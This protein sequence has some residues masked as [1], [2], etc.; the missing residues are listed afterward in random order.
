MKDIEP[1]GV[2]V[3]G[4]ADWLALKNIKYAESDDEVSRLFEMLAYHTFKASSELGKLRGSFKAFKGSQLNRG[5]V[6]GKVFLSSSYIYEKDLQEL[7]T[8]G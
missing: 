4:L 1:W 8:D 3:M 6:L 2:G 5:I 7:Y